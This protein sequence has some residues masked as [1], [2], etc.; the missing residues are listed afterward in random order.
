MIINHPVTECEKEAEEMAKG[1]PRCDKIFDKMNHKRG[2]SY[3][4]FKKHI[5][6][7]HQAMKCTKCSE[8]FSDKKSHDEHIDF[9]WHD[10]FG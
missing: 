10:H 8:T 3:S 6:E 9:N 1:C 5:S 2:N 7:P 4:Y